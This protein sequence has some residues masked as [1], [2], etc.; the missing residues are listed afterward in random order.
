MSGPRNLSLSYDTVSMGKYAP[1]S[2]F[3]ETLLIY[4]LEAN[5]VK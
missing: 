3:F 5:G 4:K 2:T 1:L